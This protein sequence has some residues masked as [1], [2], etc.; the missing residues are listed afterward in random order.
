M[1]PVV[2][3]QLGVVSC[4][5]AGLHA[6]TT[7]LRA[8]HGGLRTCDFETVDL[9]T[10]IGR[11]DGVE[12]APLPHAFA[13]YDCRNNR[14]A[15]LAL[16]Q[17]G[18][19]DAVRVAR[20]RYGANRIGVFAGTSTAGILA[21]EIAFRQRDAHDGRLPSGFR[22]REQ[23]N[24]FS[25]A[26]FVQHYFGLS[27]PAQVVSAACASTAI[28]FGAAARMLALGLC[29]AVVVGGADS[30]CLTT[31]YGFSALQLTSRQP[32]CP[33]DT[34]RDGISIGE[35]AGFA[36]L[37]RADP[38]P[39]GES[40]ALLGHGAS[41]DAHHMSSPHPEGLGARLAMI[42]ALEAAG[43][44]PGDIDYVNLHGTATRVGDAA[45]DIAVST[46]FGT[47]TPCGSTKGLTG[48]TLGAAGILEAIIA[49]CCLREGFIPASPTTLQLDPALRSAYLIAGATRALDHVMSNSFGFGGSNC[50][51]VFGR[52]P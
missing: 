33:F 50:S 9:P 36:L 16:A 26:D 35:A 27:G 14:L 31:L 49:V 13:D 11:V 3:S 37:E 23:H 28:V 38:G 21:T 5:G 41:S 46:L 34:D 47:T 42:E 29:D 52:L 2:I 22:Y 25:V 30:L 4:L 45:E 1:Q 17:D 24:T 40:I 39:R 10:W 8:G 19:A 15:A 44:A 7:A 43:L 20:E 51:L 18:F 6:T 12:D 48:H 32:C